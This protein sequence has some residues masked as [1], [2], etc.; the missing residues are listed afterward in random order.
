MIVALTRQ[1]ADHRGAASRSAGVEV[2]LV[3]PLCQARS[4]A[5]TGTASIMMT[6]ASRLRLAIM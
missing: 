5:V 3:R 6:T 1:S 2:Q 4:Y